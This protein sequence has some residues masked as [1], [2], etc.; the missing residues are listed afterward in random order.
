MSSSLDWLYC[1]LTTEYM[2]LVDNME[3]FISLISIEKRKRKGK[4][5]KT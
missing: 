5:K 1:T 2:G 3:K 4:R